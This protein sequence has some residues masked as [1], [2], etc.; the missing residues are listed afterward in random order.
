MLIIISPAKTL[1][2]TSKVP[3]D[4]RTEPVF[5]AD[6]NRLARRM[7]ELSAQDISRLMSVSAKLGELNYARYQNWETRACPDTA[8]QAIFA[9]RGDVYTGLDAASF[10]KDDLS[11]AQKRLRI[12]SGLYGVLRP[13]D[14]MQAYRLEMGARLAVGKAGNLYEFWGARVTETLNDDLAAS[15]RPVLVNLASREYSSVVLPERVKAPVIAPV[16]KEKRGGAYKIISFNAKKA[17]G[18]MSRFIIRNRLTD[19]DDLKQF[20]QAGYRYN[21]QSS[22][23]NEWWFTR[24]AA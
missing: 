12:L 4:E 16:F 19:A 2:Y 6:A 5:I 10:S 11:F 14:M 7:R 8:R 9:F 24:E 18:L 13:F 3:I 17:R 22:T 15:G 21:E 20:S 23:P 1:D